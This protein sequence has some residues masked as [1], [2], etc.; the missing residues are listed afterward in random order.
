MTTTLLC[1]AASVSMLASCGVKPKELSAPA[2]SESTVF[3]GTYPDTSTEPK[4]KPAQ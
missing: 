2:G 1:L 4:P 3:P